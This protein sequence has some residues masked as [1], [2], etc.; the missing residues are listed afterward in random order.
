LIEQNK[1]KFLIVAICVIYALAD[2]HWVTVEPNEVEFV[3]STW[4]EVKKNEVEIL[5]YIFKAYPD[6]QAKF[7]A[8]VGKDLEELK[9][10][11]PFALHATRIV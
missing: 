7:P 6:I 11:T 9:G 8:F 1:M 5:Y 10:T 3:K 2:P 4:N